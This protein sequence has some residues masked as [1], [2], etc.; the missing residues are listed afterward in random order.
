MKNKKNILLLIIILIIIIGVG[1]LL[2]FGKRNDNSNNT[3]KPKDNFSS[4]FSKVSNVLKEDNVIK[5]LFYSSPEI[6][7]ELVIFDNKSYYGL[8]DK[9]NIKNVNDIYT[10]IDEIYTINYKKELYNDINNYN[11]FANYNNKVYVNIKKKCFIEDFDEKLLS[12]IKVE[13]ENITFMYDKKEYKISFLDDLYLIDSSP[14]N[15]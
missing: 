3:T 6:T 11:S 9:Y 7:E 8:S 10:K 15:C 14:F 2:V 13:N 4:Y 1:L 12:I 5:Q